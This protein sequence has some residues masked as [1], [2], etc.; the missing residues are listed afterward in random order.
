[1]S[2]TFD[3]DRDTFA[4]RAEEL[5]ERAEERARKRQHAKGR[6]TARERI[7]ALVDEDTFHEIHTFAGGNIA[8]AY[9]GCAVITG[10]G[11]INGRPV[12]VYAQDFSVNGGTLGEVEGHKICHLIDEALRLRIPVFALLD[13]GGARIQEG[14]AALAQYGNIFKKISEAS[15]IVPQ[16]SVILGPCAG[17]AVYG[18]ALTDFIIMTK[19][20]SY[21]FV[22]G[23]QVVRAVTG[24]QVSSEDLGGGDL[25]STISGVAHY[26]ADDEEDALQFARS[27]LTYL[28]LHCEEAPPA[29]DYEND[30]VAEALAEKVGSLVPTSSKQPYDMIEVIEALTDYGEF[31]EIQELFGRSIVVGFACFDGRSVGIVANQPAFDAGTLDVNASEKAA[32]FVRFCDAF[33]LPVVT[34]VDVPGYRPGSEQER[35]GIIRRGAKLITAYATATVPLVTVILRKAYGG[36]YIVMGSKSLGADFNFS[37]P[38][39]EIAVMGS[40]GAVDILFRKELRAAGEDGA[41]VAAQ[42]QAYQ[43]QYKRESISPNLSLEKGELDS[44]IN[45]KDTRRLIVRSLAVLERKARSYQTVKYHDNA[46]L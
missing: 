40:E 1:M 33:G 7:A 41:D 45:P 44:L 29:Y 14:V 12:A 32:R 30:P 2:P 37:W 43:E 10:F 34:L 35:A 19:R 24:E 17:G 3:I 4:G 25:H 38:Q 18:P 36:A 22:T 46:P 11:Q 6:G 5:K 8:E 21:M 15:G 23:P 13:S 20:S 26:L 9:L 28:P 27:I 42:R 39:T 16:I 31:V